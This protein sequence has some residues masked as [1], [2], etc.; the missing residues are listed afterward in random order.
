MWFKI[1]YVLLLYISETILQV[2]Y[3]SISTKFFESYH[4]YYKLFDIFLKEIYYFGSVKTV[5]CLPLYFFYY[6]SIAN[7]YTANLKAAL[8][9]T[10]IFVSVCLF[11]VFFSFGIWSGLHNMVFLS[12]IAFTSSFIMTRYYKSFTG[13]SV[14]Q[15]T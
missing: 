12:S 1:K 2:L 11:S 5:F 7:E 15:D 6:F 8:Y 9:H 13:L 14:P 3:L 4:T 10:L